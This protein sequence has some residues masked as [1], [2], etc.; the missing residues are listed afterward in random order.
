MVQQAHC[1]DVLVIL[2][3]YTTQLFRP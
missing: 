3:R 1:I 2:R